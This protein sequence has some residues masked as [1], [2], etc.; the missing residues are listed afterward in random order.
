MF[1]YVIVPSDWNWKASA[2]RFSPVTTIMNVLTGSSMMLELPCGHTVILCVDDDENQLS[3]R[4]AV[5]RLWGYD[6]ISTTDG[7]T[8]LLL[9]DRVV[10]DIVVLDYEMPD[11]NGTE[12]ANAIRRR[13][14]QLPIVGLSGRDRVEL[15]SQ[16]LCVI[17]GFVHKSSPLSELLFVLQQ[18]SCSL[19]MA[20]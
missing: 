4:T 8:A 20:A 10:V 9:L 2:S 19:P 14:S 11:M 7:R 12:V 17:D 6:V 5:L 15:S 13:W 3:V 1:R 18:L 16:F